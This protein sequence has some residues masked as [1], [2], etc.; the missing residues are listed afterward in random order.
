MVSAIKF[1][2]AGSRERSTIIRSLIWVTMYR[3]GLWVLP[4]SVTRKW[5]VETPAI[6]SSAYDDAIVRE[7]VRGVRVASRFIPHAS[8]L[9]QALA[10]RKLL[11][12]S[13]QAAEL[14]IGVANSSGD[15]EAH[16]W[17]EI[18]GRIV[19]GKQAM[20]SRYVVLESSPT[21]SRSLR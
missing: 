11:R 3:I 12:D 7:V 1:L 17:L 10:A 19:L 16:A 4:F 15:F 21:A 5:T 8:C 20:H 13:G 6:E 18:D 14:K 2:K 9:T